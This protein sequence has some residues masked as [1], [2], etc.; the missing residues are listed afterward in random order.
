MHKVLLSAHV[1]DM[2]CT[3]RFTVDD[4]GCVMK[5]VFGANIPHEDQPYRAV[6]AA[7]HMRDAL[8]SHRIQAALVAS[9]EC[10][11]GPVGAA[12]RRK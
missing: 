6:L 5:V 4:K 10:L 8:S 1:H 2:R 11:I 12:W 9:G 3:H 7:L